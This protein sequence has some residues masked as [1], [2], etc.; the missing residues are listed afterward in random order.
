MKNETSLASSSPS[1]RLVG[2]L[3]IVSGKPARVVSV[4]SFGGIE[5]FGITFREFGTF[6]N[7]CA[8]W[9]PVSLVEVPLFAEAEKL[10]NRAK[11]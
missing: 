8:G 9:V 3:V 5:H 10:G 2:S 11:V 6:G 1:S 7:Y 4:G